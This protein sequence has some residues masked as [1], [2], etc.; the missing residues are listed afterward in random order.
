[1]ITLFSGTPGS[2][3]SLH[4]AQKILN[5]TRNGKFYVICNFEVNLDLLNY[6]ENFFYVPNWE[7][8]P[9]LLIDYSMF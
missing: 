1:M 9:D 2:G 3:K 8:T 6:P 4:I 7:L 5:W